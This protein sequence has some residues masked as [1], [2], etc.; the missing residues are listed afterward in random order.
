VVVV[1]MVRFTDVLPARYMPSKGFDTGNDA[2][3]MFVQCQAN[4]RVL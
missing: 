3:A 1:R 4:I 2:R